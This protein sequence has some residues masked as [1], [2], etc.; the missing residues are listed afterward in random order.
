[1]SRCEI[2]GCE[3]MVDKKRTFANY[4]RL[5]RKKVTHNRWMNRNVENLEGECL[6]CSYGQK[7]EAGLFNAPL[8][9]N[10]HVNKSLG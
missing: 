6:G 7:V 1:M 9:V 3:T 2:V 8:P 5:K 10:I 4:C